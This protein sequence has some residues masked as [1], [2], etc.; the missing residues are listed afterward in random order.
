MLQECS[1]AGDAGHSGNE[2]MWCGVEG[3]G[4]SGVK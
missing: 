1:M 2:L 3:S 4:G